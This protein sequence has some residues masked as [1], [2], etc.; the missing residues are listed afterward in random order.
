MHTLHT[1]LKIYLIFNYMH[2]R[3][4]TCPQ[5][6]GKAL[7]LLEM[8]LQAVVSHPIWILGTELGLS[9]GAVHPLKH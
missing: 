6:L 8:E 5:S 4:Y 9:A 7:D 2:V 1:F 3:T